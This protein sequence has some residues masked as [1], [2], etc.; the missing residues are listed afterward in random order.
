MASASGVVAAGGKVFLGTYARGIYIVD[1][2]DREVKLLRQKRG[3]IPSDSITSLVSTGTGPEGA[4]Y[5]AFSTRGRN[6]HGVALLDP[7]TLEV[8]ALSPSSRRASV[9]T[10]PLEYVRDLWWS[11][12]GSV[13]WAGCRMWRRTSYDS[14]GS[15]HVFRYENSAWSHVGR[16]GRRLCC[17]FWKA[18]CDGRILHCA[19]ERHKRPGLRR[20]TMK[21]HPD[22]VLLRSDDPLL[23][24]AR[25][26]AWDAA[27]LWL[28]TYAG[29]Y[30][31]DRATGTMRCVA[32]KDGTPVYS[33]LKDGGW[34]Y[35][36]AKDGIYR[37]RIR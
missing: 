10:E 36:G 5:M 33:I 22:R 21:L 3:Q 30:E 12:E 31:V 37:Y 26:A 11:P 2:P 34:L 4:V 29:L 18:V 1:A 19:S 32:H 9:H 27:R 35:L 8:R 6:P 25:D 20:V 14:S 17:P 24:T 15:M 28:A 16:E 7:G 13:L 23:L